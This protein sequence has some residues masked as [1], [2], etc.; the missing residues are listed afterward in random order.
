MYRHLLGLETITDL[1]INYMFQWLTGLFVILSATSTYAQSKAGELRDIQDIIKKEGE[2]FIAINRVSPEDNKVCLE[3]N[4]IINQVQFTGDSAFVNYINYTELFCEVYVMRTQYT[5]HF[6]L[7]DIDPAAIR[8]VEKKYNIGNGKL[9]EGNP[10][11]FEVQLFTKNNKLA[12]I[13]REQES[14]QQEILTTVS[15]IVKD[16][17]TARQVQR[18]L[19]T[20][21]QTLQSQQ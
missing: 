9:T 13:K 14:I 3:E 17:D 19:K 4:S 15:L 7:K 10:G 1:K 18:S 2:L 11:W 16:E 8:L 21:L 6:A 12:I 5:F 20:A